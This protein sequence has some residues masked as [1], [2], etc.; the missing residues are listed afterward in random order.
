MKSETSGQK[1]TLT[2]SEISIHSLNE[3]WDAD[4]DGYF[5][6]KGIFQSTHSMKSETM[7]GLTHKKHCIFQSTHSMKSETNHCRWFI[8]GDWNFNPLTQWRVRQEL[9]FEWLQCSKISIHSLNEEWDAKTT[10]SG[11][12][13]TLFQ[14]T[15][16]MKS[17]TDV[18]SGQQA[19][20]PF[21]S[22]HSMKSETG[23]T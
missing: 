23:S 18:V 1:M 20:D 9:F 2:L 6:Y 16:S 13:V 21:Q 12:S 10:R 8:T 4:K 15:H 3:E 22:T 7:F 11:S 19:F 17:E 5:H 14:S